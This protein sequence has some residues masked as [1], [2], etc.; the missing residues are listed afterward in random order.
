MIGLE[1]L[2]QR[3]AEHL[4]VADGRQPVRRRRGEV[5]AGAEAAALDERSD[6]ELLQAGAGRDQRLAAAIGARISML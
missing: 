1:G 6:A 2:L 4:V 3:L 5:V